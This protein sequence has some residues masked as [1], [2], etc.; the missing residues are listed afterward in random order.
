MAA[1]FT[2][3]EVSF[4]TLA[5]ILW[6]PH[7]RLR[8]GG[9]FYGNEPVRTQP[10]RV[11]KAHFAGHMVDLGSGTGRG[12]FAAAFLH[13][14]DRCIGIEILDGLAGL[15]KAVLQ[16]ALRWLYPESWVSYQS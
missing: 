9:V 5:T 4:G 11:V 16:V 14:F 3:G 1:S 8:P 12:V 2:Y 15:S 7:M 13:D 6:G 10:L